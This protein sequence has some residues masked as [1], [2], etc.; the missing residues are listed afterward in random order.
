MSWNRCSFLQTSAARSYPRVGNRERGEGRSNETGSPDPARKTQRCHGYKKEVRNSRFKAMERSGVPR[1]G[2]CA[3]PPC[4]IS[5]RGPIFW[6]MHTQSFLN[7]IGLH[8]SGTEKNAYRVKMWKL[9]RHAPAQQH[10]QV[11]WKLTV[12]YPAGGG[13]KDLVAGQRSQWWDF[14]VKRR[15]LRHAEVQQQRE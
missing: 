3:R 1:V 10:T 15:R 12:Y 7:W 13:E 5:V 6:W 9:C 8:A 14:M 2:M 11:P 4:A